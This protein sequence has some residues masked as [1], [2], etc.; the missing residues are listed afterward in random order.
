MAFAFVQ[1][2]PQE[3]GDASTANYDAI[4]RAIMGKVT[5]PDGTDYSHG[6]IHWRGLPNL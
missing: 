6:W 4:H 5:E 3:A 2:F 1:D